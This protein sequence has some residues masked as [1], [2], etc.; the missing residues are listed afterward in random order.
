MIAGIVVAPAASGRSTVTVSMTTRSA[1]ALPLISRPTSVTSAAASLL[2]LDSR[3]QASSGAPTATISIAP[4]MTV[5]A[6]P[7]LPSRAAR[8]VR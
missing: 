5:H 7:A 4:P 2:T 1:S 8:P 3:H 6:E